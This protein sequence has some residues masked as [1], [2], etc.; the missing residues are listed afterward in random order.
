MR[1]PT[2]VRVTPLC[3]R[4]FRSRGA[5]GR[6]ATRWCR[7]GARSSHAPF[8]RGFPESATIVVDLPRSDDLVIM[9]TNERARHAP[10]SPPPRARTG[11]GTDPGFDVAIIGGGAAGLSAALVL[12]R[13]RRRVVVMD[14]G[15]PRNAPAAHMQGYL[16]P[17]GLPPADL[18]GRGRDE[19]TGL[20]R[21]SG[22][23]HRSTIVRRRVQPT[24][25]PRLRRH[26][27]RR[28]VI[29][30]PTR[31]GDHWPQGP[32]PRHPR[33]SANGGDA[34]SF[35]ART[36][37]A[38]RSATSRSASSAAPANPGPR[39]AHA[40]VVPRRRLFTHGDP[41]TR[42]RT[43]TARRLRNRHR[44]RTRRPPRHRRR[45][46]DRRRARRGR[47]SSP[48]P[49]CSSVPHSSPTTPC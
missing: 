20:R 49:L 39:A 26:A 9:T 17:D 21:A 43:R 36:A 22:R 2:S 34:T 19:V 1:A 7:L 16:V 15:Q 27:R 10:D 46:A 45:S 47:M 31:P 23:R 44:R 30:V 18:L 12:A 28:T 40:A 5:P 38:T 14:G 33:R 8:H 48:R 4:T 6:A 41:L 11:T 13:A 37:T 29:C 25:P 42:V 35:T 3:S 32:D 24:T